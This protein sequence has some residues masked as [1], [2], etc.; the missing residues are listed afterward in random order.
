MPCVGT[1][2]LQ[3][4][5]SHRAAEHEQAMRIASVQAADEG[6]ILSLPCY[7]FGGLVHI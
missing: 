5:S 2:R 6:G 7:G 1:L 4:R 3:V